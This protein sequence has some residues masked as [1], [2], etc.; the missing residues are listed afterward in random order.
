MEILDN[1]KTLVKESFDVIVVGGG[2]A[3]VS[4]A[5]AAARL[6]AKTLILEKSIV[7][8][9]LATAGLI[10]WYEP[11]CDGCGM[12]MVG[13]IG[14]ELIRLSIR[15]GFDDMP[16]NWKGEDFTQNAPVTV[17][18]ESQP[19]KRYATHYSPTLFSLA[20]DEYLSENGVSLILDTL[21][22]YPVIEEGYVKGIIAEAKEG[23]VFYGA[24]CVIDAT[25]DADVFHKAGAPT[26]VGENF[27]SYVA[28]GIN[29]GALETYS[30]TRN[31]HNLRKWLF[32]GSD[33]FGKG[34]PEGMP[35]LHGTTS[36]EITEFVLMGRRL[37]FKSI[38][39]QDRNSR[40][41]STL[42]FMPQFRTIR[43]LTGEYDFKAVDG[44]AFGDTIGSCGDFRPFGRN[45]HYQIPYG[46][47]YNKAFPN[48]LAAGRNISASGDGWEVTRVIPVCALTGQAAGSAAA[49]SIR[50]NAPVHKVNIRSLQET[51]R[52]NG[53]LFH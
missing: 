22:T 33:L 29:E 44:E 53:V 23:K 16:Q 10:S 6:G 14:E 27:L 8:G 41:V 37:L 39:E 45:K 40:D 35:T 48:L 28:H 36:E 19:A 5:V 25:G 34:H 12:K 11:L 20:L 1:R 31:M 46:A 13:G 18:S 30:K 24:K 38:K 43:H 49:L 47:L 4:A 52:H 42:S 51:L 15:Y 2:I 7:L 32:M 3:G 50:E 26:V 17:E 21:M 9:G